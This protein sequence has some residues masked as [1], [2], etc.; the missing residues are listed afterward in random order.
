MWAFEGLLLATFRRDGTGT[1]VEAASQVPGQ[2]FDW[3]KSDRA[4]KTLFDEID[5]LATLQP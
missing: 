4:F 2:V 5:G 1:L 3:G